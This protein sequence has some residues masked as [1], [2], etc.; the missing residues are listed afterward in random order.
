MSRLAT[1]VV[2]TAMLGA[3]AAPASGATSFADVEDEVMCVSCNVPLNVAESPQAESQ[4]AEI[5]R[6]IAA[7]RSKPQIKEALVEQYGARVLAL[8]RDDGF[9][10]A[11]Y[12]VPIAVALGLAG[13]A[14]LLLPRWRARGRETAHAAPTLSAGESSRLQAELERFDP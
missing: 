14:I 9:G 5:R 4:R 3:L 7:G 6:L 13:L 1:I 12:L 8:P 10:L 11:A 2:L